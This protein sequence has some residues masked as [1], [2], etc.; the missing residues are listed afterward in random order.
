[1]TV[2]A[3]TGSLPAAVRCAPRRHEDPCRHSS[4][5]MQLMG[6]ACAHTGGRS[7]PR[8]S[9]HGRTMSAHTGGRSVR[10]ELWEEQE[11]RSVCPRTGGGAQQPGLIFLA[12][13]FTGLRKLWFKV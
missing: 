12:R 6:A 1:M 4:V 2:R 13:P 10:S 7:A 8:K 3:R 5:R 9:R 11:D